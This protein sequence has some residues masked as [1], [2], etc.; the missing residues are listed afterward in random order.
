MQATI[1]ASKFKSSLKQQ[2]YDIKFSSA[3]PAV[4]PSGK[5]KYMSAYRF[6]RKEMVSQ[7]KEDHPDFDGK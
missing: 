5:L 7:A 6:F 1:E 2:I 3:N 4:K